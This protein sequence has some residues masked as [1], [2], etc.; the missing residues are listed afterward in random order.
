MYA[1]I[2]VKH[3]DLKI[4]LDTADKQVEDIVYIGW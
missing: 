4:E 1:N 3:E 2:H